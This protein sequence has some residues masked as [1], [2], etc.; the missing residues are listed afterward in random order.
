MGR[1]AAQRVLGQLGDRLEEGER[2]V[3]ADDGGGLEKLLV[4]WRQPV[5]ARGEDCLH[6][7]GDVDRVEGP[8]ESMGPAD[9]REGVRLDQRSH[10]LLEK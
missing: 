2:H 10:T 3:L 1:S 4:L 5:D 7:C 9:S 6:R 8:G